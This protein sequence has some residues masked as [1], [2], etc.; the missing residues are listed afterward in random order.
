MHQTV[1]QWP[2]ETGTYPPE[3]NQSLKK[4]M[5][6]AFTIKTC[7]GKELEWLTNEQLLEIANCYKEVFNESWGESWTTESA[8]EEVT[9]AL[10][11]RPHRIPIAAFLY[12]N[13]KV[14][15]FSWGLLMQKEHFIR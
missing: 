9:D 15:G 13:H 12:E 5:G 1:E 6:Q 8:L 3:L 7:F 2:E 10:T 4:K 14:V 11:W